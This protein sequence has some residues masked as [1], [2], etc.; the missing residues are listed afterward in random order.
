M[1]KRVALSTLTG[2]TMDIYN[3]IRSNASFSFQQAVPEI[4]S[5]TEIPVVGEVIYG[6]PA[7]A[8]EF[9]NALVN[10]I[11]LVRIKSATFNN[12]YRD[13]KKGYL[14][15]GETVEEIFTEI[16]KVR[17]FNREDVDAREFIGF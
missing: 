8:N 13:L 10:R 17:V 3:A 7:L 2:S 14:Q 6:T 15:F 5:V 16:A 4:S 9:I 11:A 12:P 1:P